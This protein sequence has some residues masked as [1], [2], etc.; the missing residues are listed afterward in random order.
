MR[1]K[2]YIPV[3]TL[4]KWAASFA[5]TA[6]SQM[7]NWDEN[8]DRGWYRRLGSQGK[9]EYVIFDSS[10]TDKKS[11]VSTSKLK[12]LIRE[13][14]VPNAGEIYSIDF[15]A[16]EDHILVATGSTWIRY[17]I[18]N[19]KI[20]AVED[21]M[22]PFA[23]SL[24][25]SKTISQNGPATTLE[26][27]NLSGGKLKISWIRPGGQKVP[28][29]EIESGATFRQNT[30]VGHAWQLKPAKEL[31][32]FFVTKAN[33]RLVIRDSSFTNKIRR[34]E[35]RFKTGIS[36]KFNPYRMKGRSSPN[37]KYFIEIDNSILQLQNTDS[38]FGLFAIPKDSILKINALP[39]HTFKNFAHGP[40]QLHLPAGEANEGE[41]YW[42][43]DSMYAAI[44]ETKIVPERQLTL[45]RS[46]PKNDIQPQ[47]IQFPYV[48]PGD[49]LPT[50]RL[51]I[52]S[53]K[54]QQTI[55]VESFLTENPF[56]LRFI[57]WSEDN[58][59]AY[60][61]YN[62]RGHQNIRL[63][64]INAQ[65]GTTRSIVEESSNTFIHYSDRGKALF[66]HLPNNQFLWASE[67][68]GYNHLYR[69]SFT[70]GKLLN[71]VTQ[72]A[73]NF[74]RLFKIDY[75]AKSLWFYTKGVM[76]D[77]DP[78]HKHLCRVNFDGTGFKVLT[79]GDGNHEALIANNKLFFKDSYSR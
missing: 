35:N 33:Q 58:R 45:V 66:L 38:L 14:A 73:W 32:G 74:Y 1:A 26:I 79:P 54:L 55:E 30:F 37:A 64:E 8:G 78:Y 39:E 49:P 5:Y 34:P 13:L 31:P 51:R 76:P 40:Y 56:E 20:I 68:T 69:Y 36:Q 47:I 61:W 71:A 28:Y 43:P 3:F 22:K 9:T 75:E 65:T 59:H 42:S 60:L 10:T 67:R 57:G 77:Q 19:Q 21:E 18:H 11:V 72:G 17:D 27:K 63:I 7:L 16:T 70:D 46:S 23:S 24:F 53:T 15:T 52:I 44:L 12:K 2:F 62:E 41:V 48:K 29:G 4:G 25:H 50:K 6:H